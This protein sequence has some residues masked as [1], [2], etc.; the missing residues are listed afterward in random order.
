MNIHCFLEFRLFWFRNGYN[1]FGIDM[2]QEMEEKGEPKLMP[3]PILPITHNEQRN[4]TKYSS[5]FTCTRK[6]I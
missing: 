6:T 5:I 1:F 2:Y 4:L 3:V